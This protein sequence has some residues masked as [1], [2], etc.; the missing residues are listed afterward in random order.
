MMAWFFWIS[1]SLLAL[2]WSVGI[3]QLALHFS[4][5]ADLTRPEWDP[6]R[7]A[8]LPP[9]T[10]IV[11]ARNE[12]AEI[13]PALRSLLQLDYPQYE[14]I[15]VD[16][17]STDQTGA[18]MDALTAEPAAQGKLR[19][20]HIKELPQG[21]LGKLHAM[22]V[23]SLRNAALKNA[24]QG[25]SEW[26]LFTDADC[27]FHPATLRRALHYAIKN[28]VDHLVLFPTGHMKTLGERMLISFPQVMSSF[29]MRPWKIRDPRA[30]DHIGVGAF[31]LVRRS[32]YEAIGTYENLRLEVVD[33]IKFGESIKKAG[34]RQDVVYGPGLVS[35]RWGKGAAGIIANLEKNMFAFLK[36]RL[37]L[38]LAV[39]ALVCF[40]C[41]L[42]FVALAIAPG[43]SRAAFAVAV[44]MIA[45]GYAFAARV[46]SGSLWLFLTCPFSAILFIVAVLRSTITTLRDG[47]VTWRGTKYS[48]EELKKRS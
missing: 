2:I 47:A 42:P 45:L 10:V 40:M 20:L 46:S 16:D 28:R 48:L 3:L 9:L 1:G 25:S 13:E 24:G 21:W 23:G 36:Y 27:V 7:D 30:R 35:L 38:V 19:V 34:L 17:R 33:D 5:I 43:W 8:T 26:L 44:A 22:W 12:E 4:E 18:I 39:C 6:P 41:I 14:V 32:A 37:S 15:A 29:A 11:P 31:N